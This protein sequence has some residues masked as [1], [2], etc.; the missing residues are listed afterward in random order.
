M[1]ANSKIPMKIFI[2]TTYILMVTVNILANL[3]PINGV[4]TGQVSAMYPNLFAPAAYTFSIWGLIYLLLGLHT[5]YQLGFFRKENC[6][7]VI[8]E[9]LCN[10][11]FYFSISSI[12]N[13]AWI[14]SWHYKMISLSMLFMVIILICLILINE[15][16]SKNKLN[17]KDAFFIKLPFSIYFGW[18]TVATIAN[19]TSLLVSWGWSGF[20]ISEVIW[21]IIVLIIGIIIGI[22]TLI[23]NKDIAYDLALIWGYNGI[24][25]RHMSPKGFAGQYMSIIYTVLFCIAMLIISGVYVLFNKRR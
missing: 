21:T 7:S 1:L 16:T 6:S 2:V 10:V 24:L 22:A 3:I 11:G 23:K 14:L 5:L 12:A 19:V 9:L 8:N 18:I 4:T 25:V 15:C 17:S 13:A 20:G